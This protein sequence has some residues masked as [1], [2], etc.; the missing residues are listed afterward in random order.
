MDEFSVARILNKSKV[1]GGSKK[2]SW[3][4]ENDPFVRK[5]NKNRFS[6]FS[7]TENNEILQLVDFKANLAPGVYPLYL[8]PLSKIPGPRP[9]HFLLGNLLKIIKPESGVKWAEKYGTVYRCYGLLNVPKVFIL[10]EKNIQK[11]L[12][13]DA[14]AKFGKRKGFLGF[15]NRILGEGIL[16]VDGDVHKR[17]RKLMNPSF[18]HNSIRDMIPAFTRVSNALKD[19]WKYEIKNSQ[20]FNNDINKKSA[21]IDVGH[22]MGRVSL[23]VIGIVGF[24]SEIN[25]LTRTS[26]LADT[27]NTLLDNKYGLVYILLSFVLP[28]LRLL[29]LKINQDIEN[30]STEIEKITR[31]LVQDKFDELKKGKLD[32]NDL[33]SILVKASYGQEIDKNEQMSFEEI[34]NQIMTFLVAGYETTGVIMAWALHYLSKDQE[35]QD[36]LR[37]E[38]VKEFPDKDFEPNFDQINSM[39][40]L[41]AVCKE[42]L[43]IAPPEDVMIGGYLVPK[44][45]PIFVPI[46]QIHHLASIWGGDVE[47]FNPSRWFTEKV[48]GLSHYNYLPFSTGPR[49]CIGSKLALNEVKVVLC[50]LLRNFQFHEVEGFK[51]TSKLNIITLRPDPT[52]KLRVN[53]IDY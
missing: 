46:Y 29:P 12:V 47:K 20:N 33:V 10:D 31:K 36:K 24:D 35:I 9:D 1:K 18:S 11:V 41:N 34:R 3:I 14:Y 53:E 39:E 38:I 48:K 6:V 42:T 51:V 17:Q 50:I 16:A 45:T 49:S 30:A 13:S 5:H 21:I 8:S 44:D 37:K 52:V 19:I 32:S 25:S 40:Y 26:R 4:W 7:N 22:Y 28:I 15:L 2:S 27:V 43:R 23:D